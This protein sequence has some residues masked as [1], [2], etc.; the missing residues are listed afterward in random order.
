MAS[1][2]Q[3]YIDTPDGRYF[4]SRHRLWRNVNPNLVYSVRR[5]LVL[6]LMD[7]RAELRD[8]RGDVA[9][10]RQAKS[11]LQDTETALGQRG[12]VWWTDGAPDYHRKLIVNTPYLDWWA[13]L[14]TRKHGD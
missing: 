4:V 11:R 5:K 6:D 7:V 2:K 14:G 13:E 12:E 8:A 10:I 9:R 3:S 1:R